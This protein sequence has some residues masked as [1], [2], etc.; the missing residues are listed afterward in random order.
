MMFV[1]NLTRENNDVLLAVSDSD[2]LGRTLSEGKIEFEI[3][4]G[5]YGEE[6][7]DGEEIIKA[8]RKSTIIN[9]IGNDIVDLLV[10]HGFIDEENVIKIEGISHAQ[11]VKI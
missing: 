9:A 6:K 10:K 2:L 4:K 5:F 11:M 7:V 8:A 3:S 1:H